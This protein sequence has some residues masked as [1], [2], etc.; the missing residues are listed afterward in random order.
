MARL[1]APGHLSLERAS[2][3]HPDRFARDM[4]QQALADAQWKGAA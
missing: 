2:A 4:A 1:G 3:E